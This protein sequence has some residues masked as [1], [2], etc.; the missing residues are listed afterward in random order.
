MSPP[1]KNSSS[2]LETMHGAVNSLGHEES[3]GWF[4]VKLSEIERVSN[5]VVLELTQHPEMT[6]RV[7]H[8]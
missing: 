4:W 6:R 3:S 8:V 7:V 5:S 1:V 2:V